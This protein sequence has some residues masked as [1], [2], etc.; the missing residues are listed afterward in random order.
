MKIIVFGEAIAL[1]T[2]IMEQSRETR[3]QG[4]QELAGQMAANNAAK[5]P[6]ISLYPFLRY[7]RKIRGNCRF[8]SEIGSLHAEASNR[9]KDYQAPLIADLMRD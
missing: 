1:A 6:S 3:L 9:A 4:T 8:R 7:R 5:I 2:Q